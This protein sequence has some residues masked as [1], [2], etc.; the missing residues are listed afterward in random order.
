MVTSY[1]GGL[2]PCIRCFDDDDHVLCNGNDAI[3]KNHNGQQTHA[4]HQMG[5]SEAQHAREVGHDD[6]EDGLGGRDKVP[7]HENAR[8]ATGLESECDAEEDGASC[9][10]NSG[11]GDEGKLSAAEAADVN[12]HCKVL[13]SETEAREAQDE[14]YECL[15]GSWE[16]ARV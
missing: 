6:G 13:Y 8:L 5:A 16:E 12:K 1:I 14:G 3:S 11:L 7:R 9:G 15:V 2:T 10:I 4:L